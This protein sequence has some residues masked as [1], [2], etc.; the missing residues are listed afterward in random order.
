M[1]TT[2]RQRQSKTKVQT[3]Q[4][5]RPPGNWP[6]DIGEA[7]RRYRGPHTIQNAEVLIQEEPLEI[8]NGWLVWQDM[9]DAEERRIAAVIQE[10]L[11]MAARVVNFGQAYPD[12]FEC[13]M[14]N[15][16]IFKPDVCLVRSYPPTS[17]GGSI[18]TIWLN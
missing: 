12:Q 16:D 7:Y 14:I 8:Y 4:D 2:T 5:E 9:T 3:H 10:I 13:L 6:A 15:E 11:S 17:K 1:V 18:A